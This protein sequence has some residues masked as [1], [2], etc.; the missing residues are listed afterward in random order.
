MINLILFQL[1]EQG[2]SL[3]VLLSYVAWCI[4]FVICTYWDELYASIYEDTSNFFQEKGMARN[5]NGKGLLDI[6]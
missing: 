6:F 5:C 1:L 3:N 2:F 4:G